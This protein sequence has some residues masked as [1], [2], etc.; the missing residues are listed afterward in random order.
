MFPPVAAG[1]DSAEGGSQELSIVVIDEDHARLEI[2][3]GA[4]SLPLIAGEDGGDQAELGPIRNGD[5]L[6]IRIE[7]D[8]TGDRA[9][10]LF[11][12]DAIL[13]LDLR[14]ERRGDEIAVA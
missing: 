9:E 11:T 12:G 13:G 4:E 5:G 7:F 14:E 6:L 2:A 3:A 10:D 1:F 8:D